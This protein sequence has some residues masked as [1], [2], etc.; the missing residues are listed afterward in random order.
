MS[1]ALE[2]E[3]QL[4]EETPAGRPTSWNP[5]WGPAPL[6]ATERTP[7][8][9]TYGPI[10]ARAAELMG[11]PLFPHQRYV[12]DVLG[13]VQSEQAGDQERGLDHVPPVVLAAERDRPPGVAVQ[14][15]RPDPVIAVGLEEEARLFYVAITRPKR[16]LFLSWCQTQ[17]GHYT[18]MSRF[19]L[20][21]PREF[22]QNE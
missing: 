19:L 4:L 3:E 5:S 18:H 14:E 16:Q 1:L 8:R 15:V 2:L 22:V 6:W 21:L 12:V 10:V 20:D 9:P 13:E 11:R 17:Y 7:E